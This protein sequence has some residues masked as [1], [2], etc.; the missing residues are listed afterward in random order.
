MSKDRRYWRPESEK[1]LEE[2]G[3][4]HEAEMWKL[5]TQPMVIQTT[6]ELKRIE[7]RML[8]QI[9][10]PVDFLAATSA[11]VPNVTM[12]DLLRTVEECKRQ[13]EI[14]KEA[15]AFLEELKLLAYGTLI[16]PLPM[17]IDSSDLW[18][19]F[20]FRHMGEHLMGDGLE[21][22]VLYETSRKTE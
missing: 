5:M 7:E 10:Q 6:E 2:L 1:L 13:Q 9:I 4:M 17:Q 3:R 22:V 11:T 15:Q 8:E 18:E 16:K 21:D 19:R 20:R 12:E 14:D